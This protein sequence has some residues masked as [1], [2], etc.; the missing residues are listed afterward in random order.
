ML[1]LFR[2][3]VASQDSVASASDSLD[4]IDPA[5]RRLLERH[6]EWLEQREGGV[7]LDLSK[8]SLSDI[9]WGG[10]NLTKANLLSTSWVEANLSDAI[11]TGTDLAYANMP[12]VILSRARLN[13]IGS[14]SCAPRGVA[15]WRESQR[16]QGSGTNFTAACFEQARL[17]ESSLQSCKM[18]DLRG[19]K[20][21]VQHSRLFGCDLSRG[22]P[23]EAVFT[24]RVYRCASS[25]ARC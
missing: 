8:T 22:Q 18:A 16:S 20:M 11:L 2:K 3:L 14:G 24:K 13:G 5:H 23:P 1:S 9:H 7:R 21:S 6:V 12:T 25:S 17:L 19:A 4:A 10:V 15:R